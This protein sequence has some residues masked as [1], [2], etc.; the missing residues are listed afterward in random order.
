LL[1]VSKEIGKAAKITS[2]VI[3][4]NSGILLQVTWFNAESQ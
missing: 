3:Y 4:I 2:R 1:R